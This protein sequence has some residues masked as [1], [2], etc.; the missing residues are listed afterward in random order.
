M[1]FSLGL[2]E[3]GRNLSRQAGQDV[4]RRDAKVFVCNGGEGEAVLG[5]CT[6]SALSVCRRLQ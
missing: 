6:L 4:R 3:L 5:F 1:A 2:P